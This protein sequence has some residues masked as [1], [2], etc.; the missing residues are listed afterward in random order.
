LRRSVGAQDVLFVEYDLY[1]GRVYRI[2]WRLAERFDRPVMD[3]LVAQATACY[4][5]P[6][7]DQEPEWKLS[8][9]KAL[10]RRTGWERGRRLLEVRQLHPLHGGPVYVTVTDLGTA[11]AIVAARGFASPDPETS[12]PW[13]ERPQAKHGELS[14]EERDRLVHGL[15]H[16]LSLTE[17][18]APE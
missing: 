7:Y 12:P 17:F 4:G 6:V 5:K 15:A 2:R 8:D 3:D 13:W 11:R 9:G 18:A 16:L 14:D 10:L 1:D